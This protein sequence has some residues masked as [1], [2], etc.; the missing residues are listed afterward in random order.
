MGEVHLLWS[1]EDRSS[2]I[3]SRAKNMLFKTCGHKFSKGKINIEMIINLAASEVFTAK[4]TQENDYKR[5]VMS[6]L[7]SNH[8]P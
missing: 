6:P 8:D 7:N 1:F 5:S 2:E 3:G 4:V